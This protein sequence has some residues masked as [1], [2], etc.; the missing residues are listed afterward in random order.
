MIYTIK[1][2][3]V[4]KKAE[5]N[6]FL[7]FSCFFYDPTNV[8]NSTAG[9]SAFPKSTLNIWKL[10]V[11]LPLKPGLENFNVILLV[12]EMSA[13]VHWLTFF[14]LAFFWD[15]NENW[16]FLVLWPL[17]R[18]SN[19]LAYWVSS[20]TASSFRICNSSAGIPSPSLALFVVMLPEVHLTLHSRMSGS[21]WVITPLCH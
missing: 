4:I 15:C 8:G 9:S 19:L 12:C 20:F 2:F 1:S 7:A 13:I 6:V 18:F 14:G 3:G 16:P 11:H 5:V 10:T 17:L 21:R